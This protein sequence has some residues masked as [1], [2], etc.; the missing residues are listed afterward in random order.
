MRRIDSNRYCA[1]RFPNGK[2]IA[3]QGKSSS[4][5]RNKATAIPSCFAAILL[6]FGRLTALFER[7]F[8]DSTLAVV[9]LTPAIDAAPLTGL[10][11]HLALSG[12]GRQFS[13]REIVY[14][15]IGSLPHRTVDKSVPSKFPYLRPDQ[16]KVDHWREKLSG[17][18]NLRVGLS[19]T[20]KAEQPGNDLRSVRLLD[21]MKH[22]RPVPGVTFYSLQKGET[23][24]AK[25]A[26]LIDYTAELESFD[27]TSALI[28]SLNLIITVDVVI[29]HL[30]GALNI[31]MWVLVEA[32]PY[33]YLGLSGNTT[34]WYKSARL[35]RQR[36]AHRWGTVFHNVREA[37]EV[38]RAAREPER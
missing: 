31:P 38:E 21:L 25:A 13:D 37:L 32:D 19:W 22:P 16:A 10:R 2:A 27:D 6:C 24:Q 26:S 23:E 15:L 9:P 14:C 33:W 34:V 17:D 3:W 12:V 29:A 20:G 7:S 4:S 35:F 28:C 30:T 11:N 5:G 36:R 1:S 8:R 18:I